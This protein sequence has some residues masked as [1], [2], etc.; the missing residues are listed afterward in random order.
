MDSKRRFHL[1]A[2]EYYGIS[3]FEE[4]AQ[5]DQLVVLKAAITCAI[6]TPAGDQKYRLMAT[7]HKDERSK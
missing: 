3:N 6:L 4:I 7:L 5:D 1:A 2:W